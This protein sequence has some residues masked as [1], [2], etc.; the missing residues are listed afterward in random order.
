[1][2]DIELRH[3]ETDEE[4]AACFPVMVQLRPHLA[5]AAELVGRVG[6]HSTRLVTAFWPPGRMAPRSALPVT[7]S[8]KT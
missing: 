2:P 1:M 5:D 4:I 6:R 3:A 7:G 8:R